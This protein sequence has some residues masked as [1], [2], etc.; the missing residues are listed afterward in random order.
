MTSMAYLDTYVH[1]KRMENCKSAQRII[2]E[3]IKLQK[4]H[5][6]PSNVVALD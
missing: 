1:D 3:D 5:M 2:S 6:T 4:W